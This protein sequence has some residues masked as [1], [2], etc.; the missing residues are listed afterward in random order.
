[1]N[2]AYGFGEMLG[3]GLGIA[4]IAGIIYAGYKIRLPRRSKKG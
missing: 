4:V 2:I 1:M 3:W